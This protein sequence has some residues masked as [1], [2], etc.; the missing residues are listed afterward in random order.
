MPA[1]PRPPAGPRGAIGAAAE[2]AAAAYLEG[3]GWTLLARNL[4]LGADEIDIVARDADDPPTL[5]VVE[6]RSRSGRGFGSAL[7]SMDARKVARLY[8]AALT[9]HRGAQPGLPSGL[10]LA[11]AW[12]VDLLAMRRVG[13]EWVVESHLRGL[14]PP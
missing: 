6:V 13:L 10:R 2:D 4:R 5:V 9:L 14:A 11:R 12:R 7:E 3:I 1:D 8:R